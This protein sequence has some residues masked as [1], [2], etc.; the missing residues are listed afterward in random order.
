[1]VTDRPS[2]LDAL[3]DLFVYAPVGIALVASEELPKLAAKGRAQ[4]GGQLNMARVLGQFAVTQGRRQLASRR[5]FAPTPGPP[6]D[7]GWPPPTPDTRDGGETGDN[8]SA[9]MA[10]ADRRSDLDRPSP[11]GAPGPGRLEGEGLSATTPEVP[12]PSGLAIPGYDSLAASQVVP[13]LAGLSAEELAA[14]GAYESAHRARRTILTRIH[15]LQE[16]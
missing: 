3:L 4:I 12:E 2:P 15:Q 16:R 5:S 9:A 10:G 8:T 1:M 13:R 14:V 7:G 11:G 6:S